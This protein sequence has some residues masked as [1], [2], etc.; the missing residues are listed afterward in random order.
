[1]YFYLI[2]AILNLLL[3]LL[4]FISTV[5]SQ[6]IISL[7]WFLFAY[8]AVFFIPVS[9]TEKMTIVR[10]FID[11]QV[12]VKEATFHN[13]IIF[14]FIFNLIFLISEFLIW[15]LLPFPKIRFNWRFS[16]ISPQL[17]RLSYILFL[18]WLIGGVWY[19]IQTSSQGYRDYVEGAS[20]AIVFFWASSPLIPL[21]TM[22]RRRMFAII[23]C[24]P[25]LYFALHLQVRSFALLSLVPFLIVE[26]YQLITDSGSKAKFHRLI[27][28]GLVSILIL[29]V[30]SIIVNQYKKGGGGIFPDSGMP[31]GVVQVMALSDYFHRFVG[32][33]G[34]ILYFWN[35]INPFMKLFFIPK[36]NITDT[37]VIIAQLLEGVP[38]NWQVYFHYPALIWADAYISF[39]WDGLWLAVF[40]AGILCLWDLIMMRYPIFLVLL[41]P[42]FTWH[43]YMLVRGAIAI[44][45]VPIAYALYFSFFAFLFTVGRG[46]ASTTS[47][48]KFS[49]LIE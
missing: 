39:A 43:N 30:I 9:L 4:R 47:S 48:I 5:K 26:F 33:D 35:Y 11:S 1:M 14:V 34:I 32:F 40:W 27:K 41:L 16:R 13:A 28:F 8:F 17:T 44:A 25:F 6:R 19:Y 29:V 12:T 15:R 2:I 10:G 36:P 21:M 22:Q 42:Y 3:C 7:V 23:L 45:S 37:P 46:M 20:W 31:F 18:F 38:E 49:N 24:I